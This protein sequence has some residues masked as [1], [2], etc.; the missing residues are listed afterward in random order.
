MSDL[1]ESIPSWIEQAPLPDS[2]R[3]LFKWGDPH[4]FKH[5]N[6][7]M[8]ALL[9][10]TFGMTDADFVEAQRTGMEKFDIPAPDG[11]LLNIYRPW[12]GSSVKKM[13]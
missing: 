5:P 6:R 10:E 7:G 12:S 9:K 3:S 1:K 13:C 4:G 2:Y 11:L 8:L